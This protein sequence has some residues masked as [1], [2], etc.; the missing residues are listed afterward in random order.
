M[1]PRPRDIP[2]SACQDLTHSARSTPS[3]TE[4]GKLTYEEW[5]KVGLWFEK[6]EDYTTVNKENRRKMINEEVAAIKAKLNMTVCI[7]KTVCN[8]IWTGSCRARSG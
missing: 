7:E 4:D 2:L 6:G 1:Y 3:S 8:Q 5:M